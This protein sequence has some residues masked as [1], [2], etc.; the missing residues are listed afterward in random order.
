M[1]IDEAFIIIDKWLN[2]CDHLEPL[3]FYTEPKING[4]LANAVDGG[5]LPISLDDSEKE[6]KTLKTQNRELYML[7]AKK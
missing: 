2:E 6:P 3:D 1:S 4:C 5:Y 7:V